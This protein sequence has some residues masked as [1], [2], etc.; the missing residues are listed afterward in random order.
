MFDIVSE[1]KNILSSYSKA[2][3]P[4]IWFMVWLT[5]L[6]RIGQSLNYNTQFVYVVLI[7][8]LISI[9]L[10][11]I[12]MVYPFQFGYLSTAFS[13]NFSM[14]FSCALAIIVLVRKGYGFIFKPLPFSTVFTKEG[15]LEYYLLW[16]ALLI[17]E[18]I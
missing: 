7:P 15:M 5:I 9:P 18:Y 1:I 3:I 13:L 17:H 14:C 12:L 10:Q 2:L 8:W 6:Q 11:Y 16:Y 4:W